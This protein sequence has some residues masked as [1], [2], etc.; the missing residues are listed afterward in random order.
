MKQK[1]KPL[2]FKIPGAVYPALHASA[3]QSIRVLIG[4]FAVVKTRACW[5]SDDMYIWVVP[6]DSSND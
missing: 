4:D 1:N 5:L 2:K 6:K 3:I